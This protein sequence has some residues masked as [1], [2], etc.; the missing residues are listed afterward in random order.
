MEG[1][2]A[3]HH[4][5]QPNYIASVGGRSF[6]VLT[7]LPYTIPRKYDT[8]IDK[9]EDYASHK[10]GGLSWSVYQEDLPFTGYKGDYH[11]PETGKIAY[12]RKHK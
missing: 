9:L 12:A 5:S 6:G 11:N 10:Y 3:V 4:P 8:I 1:Y 7:D 2:R